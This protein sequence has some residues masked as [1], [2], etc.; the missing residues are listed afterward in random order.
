MTARARKRWWATWSGAL[1]LGLLSLAMVAVTAVPL[2][3]AAL[4][5]AGDVSG[6]DVTAGA[7]PSTAWRIVWA[8]A[9]AVSLSVPVA[10]VV[11]ARRQWLGWVLVAF[12]VSAVVLGV[13]L[14]TLRII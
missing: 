5:P 4:L 1:A 6:T 10:V 8:L 14:W 2:V 12:A 3:A 13:G 7:G 9:G 11:T